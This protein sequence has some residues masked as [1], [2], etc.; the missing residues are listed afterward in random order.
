MNTINS[1]ILQ[2]QEAFKNGC[3][4]GII[5]AWDRDRLFHDLEQVCRGFKVTNYTDFNYSY[6]NTF[7]IEPIGDSSDYIYV[8]TFKVSFVCDA[9]SVHVT[10]YSK[11]R[12]RG[13][14]VS[15]NECASL[16]P[17]LAVVRGFAEDRGFCE[18]TGQDHDIV[19][20]GID[21]ELS[22]VATLGK[23]IFDDF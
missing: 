11:D 17:I 6:C 13:E 23:C 5:L 9:Y 12:R 10:K 8:V 4:N 16:V 3:P 14:V 22:D 15:E 7:D 2:V 21:L 18:I 20:E 19:I 1:M